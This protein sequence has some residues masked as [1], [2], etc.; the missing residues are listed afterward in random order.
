MEEGADEYI[1]E[2]QIG[3]AGRRSLEIVLEGDEINIRI[4]GTDVVRGQHVDVARKGSVLLGSSWGG[5]GYSQRNIADDVYDG[6]FEKLT[7]TS[8]DGTSVA[9]EN[10]LTLWDSILKTFSDTANSIINW[11][12]KNL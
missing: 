12:V 6:V 11:F 9:Y 7:I 5:Y 8:V 10:V 1:P 3:D 2:L 4:D